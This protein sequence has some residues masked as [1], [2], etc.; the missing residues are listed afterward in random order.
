MKQVADERMRQSF[1]PQWVRLARTLEMESAA[2]MRMPHARGCHK[3]A[4]ALEAARKRRDDAPTSS[5][6]V[7]GEL[8]SAARQPQ[9]TAAV[10]DAASRSSE[11]PS[12]VRAQSKS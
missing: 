9:E 7:P 11:R 3:A 2:R 1:R 12:I 4:E 5:G 6:R 10:L 8:I